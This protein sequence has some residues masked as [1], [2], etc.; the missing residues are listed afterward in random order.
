M[1]Y[2]HAAFN[3]STALLAL[4]Y[5]GLWARVQGSG[6]PTTL[7][8]QVHGPGF[9]RQTRATWSQRAPS[10]VQSTVHSHSLLQSKDIMN[11]LQVGQ[12]LLAIRQRPSRLGHVKSSQVPTPATRHRHADGQYAQQLFEIA[13]A[14]IS[15][16]SRCL[17]LAATSSH[18][19]PPPATAAN[20][21][22][23]P[24]A[25]LAFFVSGGGSNFKA[26]HAA[27]LDGRIHADIAVRHC[28]QS[29]TWRCC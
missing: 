21:A 25:R 8:G 27:V 23:R 20:Q 22:E 13:R 29:Q 15:R 3:L 2:A 26:I 6:G 10:C 11:S 1:R 19:S 28:G 24:K 4:M 18:G 17:P 9:T 5:D 14:S 7:V 16:S 12:R